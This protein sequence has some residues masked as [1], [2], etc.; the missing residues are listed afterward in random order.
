MN[1]EQLIIKSAVDAWTTHIG[2]TDKLLQSLSDEQLQQQT[3]PGR[4]SGVYLL[5]HLTAVHDGLFPL[6]GLGDKRYPQ[7][8]ELFVTNPDKPGAE[9]PS[10]NDLRQ[11]WDRV[12]KDL[13]Q[14]F[15]QWTVGEWLQRH[16]AVSEEDFVK[17]PHRNRLN[18]LVSRTNHLAYHLG[19]L[20][21]LKA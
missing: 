10:I 3:A 18:V 7:L 15:S 14:Y 5:G 19:Q 11:Y 12:N 20:A 21:Y 9:G 1:Q 17:E 4:N 8:E 6:F 2:R 13:H 16:A